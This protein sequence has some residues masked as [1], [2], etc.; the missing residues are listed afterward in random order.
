MKLNLKLYM[1]VNLG[2]FIKLQSVRWMRHE[3]RLDDARNTKK[4]YEA[5]LTQKPIKE[6]PKDRWK[7][8]VENGIK[9]MGIINCRRMAKDTA[10]WWT[11][12]GGGGGPCPSWT[13]EPQK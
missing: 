3:Q 12:P 2:D 11:A 1:D 13:V 5:D 7:G 9:T 10:G 6:R 4:I 8:D